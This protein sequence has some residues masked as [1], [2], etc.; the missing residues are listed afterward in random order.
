VSPQEERQPPSV[1]GLEVVPDTIDAARLTPLPD[2]DSLVQ[3]TVGLSVVATD[4]DGQI[5]RVAF[6]IEP[7]SNPRATILGALT[8]VN[9][10]VYA[11]GGILTVPRFRG[12]TYTVR[13]HAVDD[14]SLASNQGI[15]RLQVLP[16]S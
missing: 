13:V 12:A 14:D 10:S 1:S 11:G 6:T 15:G 16:D 3:D 7:A 4:P 9:D 5:A 2:Q 8:S